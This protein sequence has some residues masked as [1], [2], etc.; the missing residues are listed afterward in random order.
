MLLRGTQLIRLD[1][2]GTAPIGL[3]DALDYEQASI[4]LEPGD[5]LVLFT[6]GI[7]EA[8]NSEG[9]DWGESVLKRVVRTLAGK[10]PVDVIEAILRAAD[11]FAGGRSASTTI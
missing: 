2:G 11:D 9:L 5:L 3:F 1:K 6:D 8:E 10:S 7:S 4:E